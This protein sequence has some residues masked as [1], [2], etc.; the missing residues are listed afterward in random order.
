MKKVLVAEDSGFFGRMLKKKLEAE[1]GRQVCWARTMQEA[2]Q[3]I[4]ETPGGFAAGIVNFNL[5]DAPGGEIVARLRQKHIPVI[6][7]TSVVNKEIRDRIWEQKVVDYVYKEG[8]Q[9]LDYLVT[10]LNRLDRNDAIKV[11]VVDDSPLQRQVMAD[12]LRVH[13]YQVLEAADGGEALEH[14]ARHPDIKLVVCD[15][16]MPHMDGFELTQTI[17]KTH[18]QENLAII[19]ISALGDNVMA[20][21]FL[22]CGANDFIIKQHFLTE[23]FYC[24]ISQSIENLENIQAIRTAATTDFL[25]GISNRRFLFEHGDRIYNQMMG[26]CQALCCAVLDIDHFKKVNDTFGHQAG[27]LALKKVAKLLQEELPVSSVVARIG[28]EEFCALVPGGKEEVVPLFEGI[29]CAIA[30]LPLCM[31][32]DSESIRITVSIGISSE[33][34]RNLLDMLSRADAYLYQAKKEGRDRVVF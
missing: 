8:A 25:T 23:E 22:K 20:A 24:R 9:S 26:S 30:D 10:L 11:M 33:P 29:R 32:S 21:R 34:G 31:A 13:R 1:T 18:S 2:C 16:H 12:L 4:E 14:L 7:F 5:P 19:G 28:G 15:F 3:F 6:V 27:D 17:R